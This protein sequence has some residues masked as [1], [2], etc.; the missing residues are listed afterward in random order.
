MDGVS[1]A[2]PSQ[3]RYGSKD[4]ALSSC[5]FRQ[6]GD[7]DGIDEMRVIKDGRKEQ[8][9]NA[10]ALAIG[11]VFI[12]APTLRVGTLHAAELPTLTSCITLEVFKGGGDILA[13]EAG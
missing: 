12:R 6:S 9:V 13:S 2:A 11:R 10:F 3:S 4:G 1:K 8:T 5:L 7:E